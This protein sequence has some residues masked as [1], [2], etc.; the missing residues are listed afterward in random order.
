L[1]YISY[2]VTSKETFYA[3][4]VTERYLLDGKIALYPLYAKLEPYV[5]NCTFARALIFIYLMAIAGM[6]LM[7]R[8]SLMEWFL[9]GGLVQWISKLPVMVIK[10][11][12]H[13]HPVQMTLIVLPRIY[14]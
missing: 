2:Y 5:V 12:F 6:S 3:R 7:R 4:Y 13:L 14:Q 1:S 11:R 9:L 8:K 10:D